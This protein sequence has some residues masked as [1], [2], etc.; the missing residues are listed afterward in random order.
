MSQLTTFTRFNSRILFNLAT[1]PE[2]VY[3]PSA[4]EQIDINPAFVLAVST[5]SPNCDP[6]HKKYQSKD[7]LSSYMFRAVT[8]HMS[9]GACYKV[10]QSRDA[11]LSLLDNKNMQYQKAQRCYNE[12]EIMDDRILKNQWVPAGAFRK[13][14]VKSDWY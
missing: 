7:R 2:Y 4:K 8:I 9:N 11:V 5:E 3:T 10:L 6:D 12:G 13:M 1:D 14:N